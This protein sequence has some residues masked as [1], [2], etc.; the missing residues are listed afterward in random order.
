MRA[1]LAMRADARR[2]LIRARVGMALF[3]LLLGAA[4]LLLL[5][6]CGPKDEHRDRCEAKGGTVGTQYDHNHNV[7]THTCIVH[8]KTVDIWSMPAPTPEPNWQ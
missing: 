5:T 8:G 6:A 4:L 7:K 1:A 2:R 3:G